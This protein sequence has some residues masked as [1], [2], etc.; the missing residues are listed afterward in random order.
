MIQDCDSGTRTATPIPAT[1]VA[2][3]HQ[4]S[5]SR[6]H[7]AATTHLLLSHAA[8][9]LDPPRRAQAEFFCAALASRSAALYSD[10][11]EAF[12]VE[13]TAVHAKGECDL[14]GALQHL[15]RWVRS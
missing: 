3:G 14:R 15:G 8:P 10:E 6:C 13:A 11:Q 12:A 5:S 7:G 9:D 1:V 4:W 2:R